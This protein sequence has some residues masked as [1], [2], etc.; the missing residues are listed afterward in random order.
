MTIVC[1]KVNVHCRT[2]REYG[3]HILGRKHGMFVYLKA[4]V[5]RV[6]QKDVRD[7]TKQEGNITGALELYDRLHKYDGWLPCLISVLRDP[8]VN[9]NDLA[10]L[11]MKHLG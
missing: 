8:H 2:H 9:L 7:L 10:D 1:L 11:I 6:F 5:N 4:T 3:M